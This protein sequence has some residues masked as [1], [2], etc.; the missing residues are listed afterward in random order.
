ML[1]SLVQDTGLMR[2]RQT[3]CSKGSLV[4]VI[5][6]RIRSFKFTIIATGQKYS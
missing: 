5:S 4:L 2:T 3:W 6:S 1:L